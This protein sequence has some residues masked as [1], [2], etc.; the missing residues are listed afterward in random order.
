MR[1]WFITGVSTG[2][3]RALA[4][5]ALGVG[6][7]VI[8]TLRDPEAV[9]A[10]E[11][12]APGRAH[13]ALL[14]VRDDTRVRAVV[15]D[16]M[17]R[18][19]PIDVLVNN[20]GYGLEGAV[21]EA[22]LTE[23]HAQFDVNVFGA[24]SVIQAALP[25]MRARKSGHIINISS[26]AGLTAF[27]GVGI[28]NGSKFALEGITEALAK[29]V[30]PLGI[31]VTLVEPG[32]F[33]TDWAG[34]SLVHAAHR[35]ADYEPTAGEFRRELAVHDGRQLG[36]PHKAAAA[37]VAVVDADRPPLHLLLGSDALAAAREKIDT[38]RAEI[39]KWS[40]V[41]NATSFEGV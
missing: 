15:A 32:A 3:G 22:S 1:I 41:T 5:T 14:D 8:G 40:S 31:R 34:R 23:A 36:D 7:S 21:E 10:F 6:D 29:E 33:R 2:L 28:Y 27:P 9:P 19:G 37:I 11:A 35:I 16:E 18:I 25:S 13:A 39:D 30:A 12:L 4:E 38:L 24:L 20:A 17:D 26:I